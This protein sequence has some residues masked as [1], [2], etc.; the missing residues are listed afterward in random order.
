MIIDFILKDPFARWPDSPYVQTKRLYIKWWL[1]LAVYAAGI[2]TESFLYLLGYFSCW[3]SW[4]KIKWHNGVMSNT[5]GNRKETG[6]P[7]NLCSIWESCSKV[8]FGGS[9][10]ELS[11][12][13]YCSS[14]WDLQLSILSSRNSSDSSASLSDSILEELEPKKSSYGCMKISKSLGRY[15]ISIAIFFV[16]FGSGLGLFLT[17]PQR[18]KFKIQIKSHPN[19]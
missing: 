14:S 3:V 19:F 8:D 4:S 1:F 7:T 2:D 11:V 17:I 13:T 6:S 9:N 12:L 10:S 5:P 18:P 16:V 15:F